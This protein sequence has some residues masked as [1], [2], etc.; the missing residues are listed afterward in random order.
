MI[1]L[2]FSA[3]V[4][5]LIIDIEKTLKRLAVDMKTSVEEVFDALKDQIVGLVFTAHPTQSV[6]V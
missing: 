4:D 2:L 3:Q 6:Q 1:K 5:E